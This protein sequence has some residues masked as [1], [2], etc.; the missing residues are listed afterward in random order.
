MVFVLHL[1]LLSVYLTD[2]GQCVRIGAYVCH[3]FPL[4]SRVPQG[5]ILGIL[6]LT[7]L[8]DFLSINFD[9]DIISYENK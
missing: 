4:T 6:Y 5:T 3:P 9:G 7:Y 2:R 1:K 8:K